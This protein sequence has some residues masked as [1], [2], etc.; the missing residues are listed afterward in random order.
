MRHKYNRVNFLA[1]VL[2]VLS[3]GV[4][5]GSYHAIE[6]AQANISVQSV[7]SGVSGDGDTGSQLTTC[8]TASEFD[9]FAKIHGIKPVGLGITDDEQ[10]PIGIMYVEDYFYITET[11]RGSTDSMICMLR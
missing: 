10:T 3:I 5:F 6:E 9:E 4:A 11:R 8:Y 2:S 1:L 7:M